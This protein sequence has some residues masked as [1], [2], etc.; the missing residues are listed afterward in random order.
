MTRAPRFLAVLRAG[1]RLFVTAETGKVNS[2]R[3]NFRISFVQ[4][5][6]R[7]ITQTPRVARTK[8]DVGLTV[9]RLQLE[10]TNP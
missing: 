5:V 6:E 10:M 8:I 2:Q 7:T 3:Y 1:C 4:V 9:W